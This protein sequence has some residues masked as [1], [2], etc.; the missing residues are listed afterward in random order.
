MLWQADEYRLRSRRRSWSRSPDGARGRSSRSQRDKAYMPAAAPAEFAD[1]TRGSRQQRQERK[2]QHEGQPR[3]RLRSPEPSSSAGGTPGRHD[4]ADAG[5]PEK[6]ETGANRCSVAGG[7]GGGSGVESW[8]CKV[9][10]L[11]VRLVV[12]KAIVATA[13][14]AWQKLS[15]GA[16]G[17]G[18]VKSAGGCLQHVAVI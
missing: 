6:A 13:L 4:R 9:A 3:T 2:Q 11:T 17:A 14:N 16:G 10:A 1:A 15:G 18:D 8:C 7:V 12:R 5:Q